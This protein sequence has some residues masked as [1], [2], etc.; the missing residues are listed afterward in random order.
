MHML[1]D[2]QP[3]QNDNGHGIRPHS[4]SHTVRRFQG[5]DLAH[6]QAEIPNDPLFV[7]HD[8]GFGWAA[9]L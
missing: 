8:I 4:L 7:S 3:R 9:G 5:I 2:S 1:V 6:S